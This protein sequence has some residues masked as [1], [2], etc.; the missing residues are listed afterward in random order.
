[1]SERESWMPSDHA[2][3][4]ACASASRGERGK[5][6]ELIRSAVSGREAELEERHKREIE[7]AKLEA[8]MDALDDLWH[9]T[10]RDYSG[11]AVEV[12]FASH[13]TPSFVREEVERTAAALAA[14]DAEPKA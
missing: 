1:M 2:I 9:A 10:R 7:R 3:R 5:V 11:K 4:E 13:V 14:L 12:A 8:K 6:M